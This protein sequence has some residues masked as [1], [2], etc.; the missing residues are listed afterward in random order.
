MDHLGELLA[1]ASVITIVLS[2]IALVLGVIQIRRGHRPA[3]MRA[4]LTATALA[5]LFL[6]LY[7]SKVAIGHTKVWVGPA[8]W[9]PAYLALLASH[10]L[11]AAVN[12]PLALVALWYA[13]QGLQAAGNLDRIHEVP[14]ADA[15]FRRHRA[16]VRWTV[17]VWLYVA[18]TGWIIYVVLEKYGAVK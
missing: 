9:R 13:R 5:T 1:G 10:T 6:V 11:L 3:H 7:L 18:A 14:A 15:A 8:E 2:G 4:M 12:V 17:P 16:W